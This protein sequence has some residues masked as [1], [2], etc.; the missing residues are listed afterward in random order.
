MAGRDQ[1]SLSLLERLHRA[2]GDPE[3]WLR[4]LEALQQAISPD[5]LV[6]VGAYA[7]RYRP[8]HLVCP[9]FGVLPTGYDELLSGLGHPAVAELLPGSVL[10]LPAQ[11]RFYRSRFFEEVM[12]SAGAHPGPGLVAVLERNRDQVRSALVVLPRA[13]DWVPK[14]ADLSL[15]EWLAP[16]M[17][18]ARR[19]HMQL[20][21]TRQ[22]EEAL[23]SAFDRLVL[24]V[25]FTGRTG[26]VSYANRSA[27]EL[28]GCPAGFIEPGTTLDESTRAWGALLTEKSSGTIVS[29]PDDGRP[30]QV[31]DAPLDWNEGEWHAASLFAH[32]FFLADPRQSGREPIE[33]LRELF[34]L[35]ESETRLAAL[36]MDD[37]TLNQAAKRLGVT[38]TTARGVLKSIF[39]KTDTHRQAD[40][41]R[42]L[43][44][45]PTGQLRAV[46]P[47]E[48]LQ[49]REAF[50]EEADAAG[51]A[52]GSDHGSDPS[53]SE[54]AAALVEQLFTEP[55]SDTAWQRFF[56]TLS[57]EIVDGGATFLV[58]EAVQGA[59]S[60]IIGHGVETQ[61]VELHKIQPAG[62]HPPSEA[63][64]V[65]K[66][67]LMRAGDPAFTQ[68]GLFR[69]VLSKQGIPPGP[70]L[71]LPISRSGEHLTGAVF[72][73]APRS[74][75]RPRPRDLAL[76]ELLA[77]YIADAGSVGIRL[78]QEKT[79]AWALVRALQRLQLGVVLLDVEDRVGFVNRSAFEMLGL[80]DDAA[81]EEELHR[82]ATAAL[83]SLL[84]REP[85]SATQTLTYS[86]PDDGRPLSILLAPLRWS[87]PTDT[88][89]N[90]FT[91]ALFVSDPRGAAREPGTP[92]REL[93]RLTPAEERLT[94]Q[95]A[96]GNT[97][98]VAAENLG[99]QLSTARGV[100]RTVFR[101][102]GTRRQSS[103][104][105]LIV[106]GPERVREPPAATDSTRNG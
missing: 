17:V 106:S 61:S 89:Q 76:L 60:I 79:K 80:G 53:V 92:F 101:K 54:R 11:P 83:G 28:I 96:A 97:L 50:E 32:A 77:P 48:T 10:E 98:A 42:V 20:A 29:A 95:L 7:R 41:V 70:G 39:E 57:A 25:V 84:K 45:G 5:C 30:I 90:R 14:P 47:A 46:A 103:L 9:A 78:D 21:D 66:P 71:L 104:V 38:Q 52:R 56:A 69:A 22:N 81:P 2:P 18:I 15:L 105:R 91:T 36:L 59:T 75:W 72:L 51:P 87:E 44:R 49:A 16:H 100:L 19:L 3:A 37:C 35:T 102:T 40:L 27:S 34:G 12:A 6:L 67:A 33:G 64:P 58:G 94:R 65:G 99:I 55:G 93:Y 24:G 13:S 4:F 85:R 63:L 26:S 43:L 74:D 88:D 62:K 68:S 86:R 31:L 23:G 1:S 82:Q 8:G 73:L